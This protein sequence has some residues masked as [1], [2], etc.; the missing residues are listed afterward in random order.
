MKV[1]FLVYVLHF[2]KNRRTK[3]F[4]YVVSNSDGINEPI[5]LYNKN[6][7]IACRMHVLP[8]IATLIFYECKN[9][10]VADLAVCIIFETR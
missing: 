2:I 9:C 4:V 1:C 6:Y 5:N 8:T 10:G 3:V 7:A